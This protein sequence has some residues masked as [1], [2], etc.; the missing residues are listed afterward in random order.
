MAM[1]ANI[2]AFA[3]LAAKKL[4]MD[5]VYLHGL[6]LDALIGVWEW[7]R[8]AKQK[9]VVDLDFGPNIVAAARSDSIE[10]TID[11]QAVVT[12]ILQLAEDSKFRLVETFAET[13]ADILIADFG[14]NWVR[15]RINKQGALKEA[16][17]VG[18]IIERG[19]KD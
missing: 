9:I 12:R 6:N 2:L 15:I 1:S 17:G 3:K 19:T 16:R 4:P 5:I 7:E 8:Q 13:I 11:Y 10:D 14:V 18:V